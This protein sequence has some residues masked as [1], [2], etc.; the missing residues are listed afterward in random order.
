M[1]GVRFITAVLQGSESGLPAQILSVGA[2]LA[3]YHR[4]DSNG[5]LIGPARHGRSKR[6]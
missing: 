4:V 5:L 3:G 6:E 2:L 1:F